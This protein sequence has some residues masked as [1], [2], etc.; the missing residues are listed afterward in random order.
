MTD[1]KPLTLARLHH[2]A[3]TRR[4]DEDV[5]ALLWEIKRLHGVLLTSLNTLAELE[6]RERD[7]E[8]AK[9]AFAVIKAL[10]SEP[11]VIA[12][13]QPAP[14]R[15]RRRPYHNRPCEYEA[16]YEKR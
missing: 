6:V 3:A 16:S 5:K 8:R 12:E 1:P 13:S 11:G 4:D 14:P 15:A 9:R 10:K 7:P 2:V